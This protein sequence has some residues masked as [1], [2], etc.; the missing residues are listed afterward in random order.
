MVRTRILT[1]GLVFSGFFAS[2]LVPSAQAQIRQFVIGNDVETVAAADDIK[3]RD[4]FAFED[5]LADAVQPNEMMV[6]GMVNEFEMNEAQL[7][8]WIFSDGQD[9]AGARTKFETQIGMQIENLVELCDLTP[10]QKSKLRLAGWGDIERFF[11]RVDE[12]R[13]KHLN[14]S[15][16]QN[17]IG[18]VYQEFQPLSQEYTNGLF[19]D[20]SLL[21][22]SVRHVLDAEQAALYDE[23]LLQRRR[24]QFES[25]IDQVLNQLSRSI[26]LSDDQY[27]SIET[28]IIE[29]GPPPRSLGRM[30]HYAVLY[31]LSTV[32]EEKIRTVI[33][34]AQWKILALQLEQARGLREMLEQQGYI[35][36]TTTTEKSESKAEENAKEDSE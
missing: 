7:N 22:R 2:G 18:E 16:D 13:R 24:F 15:Y 14:K 34:D 9:A 10:T 3:A 11:D 36:D 19:G 27:S 20:R 21:A 26:G 17:K 23:M 32:P 29:S 5:D 30:D 6:M 12:V 28:L 4:P 8:G 31:R 35:D 33:D 1:L 25:K